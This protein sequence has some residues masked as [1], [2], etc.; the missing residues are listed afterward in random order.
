MKSEIE[1]TCL[2]K[3]LVQACISIIIIIIIVLLYLY[4]ITELNRLETLMIQ[5]SEY[6]AQPVA[7]SVPPS[8]NPKIGD[9]V[10]AKFS[11]DNTW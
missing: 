10:S 8:F 2:F 5:F 9:N 6:H 3:S 1:G 4:S 7:Q 11:I